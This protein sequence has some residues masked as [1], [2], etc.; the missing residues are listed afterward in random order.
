MLFTR[1]DYE[2]LRLRLLEDEPHTF[3]IVLC[4]TPVAERGEV[5]EIELLLFALGDACGGEGD[6][7]SHKGLSPALRL[8]VE[9]DAG[10][11]VHVIG[12][13]VL[14]YNPETVE[15]GHGVWA[16]GMERCLFVLRH[17]LHLAVKLGSGSL[18]DAARVGQSAEA[19]GLKD[20]QHAGGVDVG[21]ELR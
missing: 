9:E 2:I 1:G 10:A 11:A 3:H 21:G 18:I 14:L 19:H 15:L 7:A 4:V 8:V 17:F 20:A 5:A 12:L 6:L 16:V 13:A